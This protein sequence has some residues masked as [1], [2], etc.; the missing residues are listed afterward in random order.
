MALLEKMLKLG[1]LLGIIGVAGGWIYTYSSAK[2][3]MGM[4][5]AASSAAIT[6]LQKKTSTLSEQ[7]TQSAASQQATK[8]ALH[9]LKRD[10]KDMRREI[11]EELRQIR[12]S[13]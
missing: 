1:G 8:E 3:Q 13:R 4:Q 6:E 10:V 5:L 2:A 12:R 7:Q 9:E 11:M